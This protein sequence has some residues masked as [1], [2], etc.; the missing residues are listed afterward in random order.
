MSDIHV[1]KR[2]LSAIF[3]GFFTIVL[4]GAITNTFQFFMLANLSRVFTS[5]L[6]I[7][8]PYLTFNWIL[9][10]LSFLSPV[11]GGL[12]VGWMVKEKGWVYGGILGFTLGLVSM[13]IVSLTFILPS[14]MIFGSRFPSDYGQELAEK[15]IRHQLL[16][17]P[18]TVALTAL[19]GYW[20]ERLCIRKR[21]V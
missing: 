3:A 5:H 4:I 16:G 20:G 15:K 11:V 10:G 2:N 18:V 9:R 1:S 13:S 21:K 6:Y 17:W 19:G 8:Q 12:V 7:Q 14:S